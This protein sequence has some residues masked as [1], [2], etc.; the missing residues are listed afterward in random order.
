MGGDLSAESE[1]GVGSTFTLTLPTRLIS[2]HP[3]ENVI[4]SVAAGRKPRLQHALA[5]SDTKFQK[6]G[7]HTGSTESTVNINR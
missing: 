4:L 2:P 7:S 1:V 5:A 6:N 3:S